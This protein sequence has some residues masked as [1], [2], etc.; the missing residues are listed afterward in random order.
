MQGS[1]FAGEADTSVNYANLDP[2]AIGAKESDVSND[3]A[4]VSVHKPNS[5]NMNTGMDHAPPFIRAKGTNRPREKKAWLE[6]L[7]VVAGSVAGLAIGYL[8][9]LWIT[10]NDFLHLVDR[11]PNWMLP[12]SLRNAAF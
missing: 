8:L 10:G 7:K 6:A 4:A 9:I 3:V 12:P 2:V 5:H 1:T 11:M